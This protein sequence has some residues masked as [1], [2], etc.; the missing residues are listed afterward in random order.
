MHSYIK[1]LLYMD[2]L[3]ILLVMEDLLYTLYFATSVSQHGV[4]PQLCSLMSRSDL[5]GLCFFPTDIL[6]AMEY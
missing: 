2:L 1:D 5:A 3:S 6:P 4:D